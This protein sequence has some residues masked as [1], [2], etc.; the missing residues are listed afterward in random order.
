MVDLSPDN[1]P[2][3]NY[4]HHELHNYTV[5]NVSGLAP[6]VQQYVDDYFKA[7]PVNAYSTKVCKDSNEGHVRS[8]EL[9]RLSSCD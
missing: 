6:E 3:L 1:I 4:K 8:V 9:W 5:T 7:Y 2:A